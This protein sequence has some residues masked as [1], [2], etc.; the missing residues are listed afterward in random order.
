MALFDTIRAGASG[1]TDYEIQRSLRFNDSDKGY[2]SRT[3]GSAGDRRTWTWS[4]WVKRTQS[5][6][7]QNLFSVRE[8][9]NTRT[10][11]R[12]AGGIDWLDDD[13][14]FRLKTNS[15][16]RD[17][18]AWYHFVFVANTTENTSSN[19]L[20]IFVNGQQI[21]SFST[22]DYPS[23]NYQ[24]Q[25][26]TTNEHAIGREGGTDNDYHD[27]YMAEIN[28]IDGQALT[29]S[30]F[31]ETDSV[32]GEYKPIK[33][34]GS[35]GTNGFYLNFLDNSNNTASTLGKDSSG[36]GNNFTPNN[37]S[38]SS[39][40]GNDSVSDTPTNNWCTLNALHHR[41]T[42]TSFSNGNLQA[43]LPSA[44][45]TGKAHGSFVVFSGKWYW[46][47]KYTGNTGNFLYVG[48]ASADGQSFQRAVRGSDGELL[49]NTGTVSVSYTTNDIIMVALDVDNGK[50]YIGKNGSFML[51]GDPANGTG[52]VHNDLVTTF[53]GL[54]P[55]F[56]NATG[57]GGQT[58]NTNWGQQGFTYTPPTGFVAL[59]SK[60]LPTPT[61][62]N[63]KKHINSLLYTASNGS[64]QPKTLTGLDFS[65]DWVW[66]KNRSRN[67]RHALFDTVRGATKRLRSDGNDNEVADSDTLT[68]F[69]SNGFSIG[70]DTGEFGVNASD[71]SA[72]VAW[73]WDAGNSTV[74]NTNGNISSQVRVNA[75]AG[76]SIVSYSGNGS[77][78]QTVGHGLGVA[79]STIILK[80]RTVS[81]NWRVWHKSLAAD[82]SK[83]LILDQSNASE[84]AGFLND[85]AP[86]STVFTLGSSDNAWNDSGETYI[87]Y[88]FSEV[89]GY[90]KFNS[91]TGNG[92]SNGIFVSLGFRPSW[93]MIKRSSGSENWSIFDDARHANESP[94]GR[95]LRPD[96]NRSE[97]G[98]VTN[99]QIDLLSNGFKCRTSE[100]KFNANG[101]TYVYW[102]FASSPAKISRAG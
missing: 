7:N 89:A 4:G 72:F 88:C 90:S 52:F 68:S 21:T 101:S 47:I 55:Y 8:G 86:T 100:Q 64:H 44:N 94:N 15:K 26:N 36:N 95:I 48:V 78:G 81:S 80:S 82:G 33:Y 20:K 43:A 30:S 40:I 46:E 67:N 58:I 87:A 74:T 65:P 92:S 35:Y 45:A 11:I 10:I 99:H 102:A 73:C 61:I 63:G 85:T 9:S 24:T 77:N 51:S 54:M 57:S 18:N 62:L 69:D 31:A 56:Q 34:V 25:I 37:F 83:R 5:S 2:L 6:T 91:Y 93:I 3:P 19:R 98:N 28:F 38:V 84:N 14:N 66:C 59:N 22:E 75:T 96:S 97:G 1:A 16:F 39:G 29:P 49:P 12:I 79:P 42:N 71:G 41:A 32:T 13:I 17:F 70:A 60:N 50:W 53:N 76:F 23:Q 27:G